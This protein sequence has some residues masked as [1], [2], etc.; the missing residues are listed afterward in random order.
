[1][2]EKGPETALRDTQGDERSSLDATSEPRNSLI[3]E[4]LLRFINGQANFGETEASILTALRDAGWEDP[5][6]AARRQEVTDEYMELARHRADAA[7]E[8]ARKAEAERDALLP[9]VEAARR[10]TRTF[11]QTPVSHLLPIEEQAL[12]EQAA[13]VDLWESRKETP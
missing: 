2:T 1:M 6:E 12:A 7:N 11:R 13:A 4:R 9:V 5:E 3:K 8:V 10:T